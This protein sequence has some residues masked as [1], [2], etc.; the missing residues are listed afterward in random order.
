[1]AS[2]KDASERLRMRARL[3]LERERLT[4][5]L[6]RHE[7]DLSAHRHRVAQRDPCAIFNPAV[8]TEDAQQEVRS[9]MAT[10]VESELAAV[11]RALRRL[12]A[13]PDRF[14]RCERCG[15]AISPA[16]L[17]LLPHSTVCQRC[18]QAAE[19]A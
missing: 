15:D 9:G 10:E 13:A 16:R 17:D 8:A 14:G 18:A 7:S 1:M 4:R 3:E 12:G 5:R 11:D 6:A 2:R 19:S